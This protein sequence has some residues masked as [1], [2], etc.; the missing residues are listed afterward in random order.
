VIPSAQM[1]ESIKY[2]VEDETSQRKR[3]KKRREETKKE[4]TTRA[5]DRST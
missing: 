2:G 4:R 3:E 5:D 1:G